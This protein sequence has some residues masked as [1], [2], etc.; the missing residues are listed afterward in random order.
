[1]RPFVIDTSDKRCKYLYQLIENRGFEVMPLS[2]GRMDNPDGCILVFSPSK[3]IEPQDI[4]GLKQGSV[5]FGG[6][7]DEVSKLFMDSGGIAYVNLLRDENFAQNNT[8]PTAE[9]CI[10]L[11]IEHTDMTFNEL[12]IVILGY[13][14][15][16]KT[17]AK[18]LVA[19]G[20][21]THIYSIDGQEKAL[22]MMDT[23]GIINDLDDLGDFDVVVNTIP[24]NIFNSNQMRQCKEGSFFCDL[25]SGNFID[26]DCLRSHGIIAMNAPALPGK[27]SP[28]SAGG[29]ILNCICETLILKEMTI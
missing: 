1:M 12:K 25:A 7:A 8:I 13:G 9:G 28:K 18:Y 17:L 5:V 22:A 6:N 29:Y 26:L 4:R 27:V 11:I 14:R 21:N 16:G 10:K 3:I 15:V 23:D 24:A 2:D 19:L 20:I